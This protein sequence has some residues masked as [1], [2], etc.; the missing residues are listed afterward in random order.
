M[1][2]F[3]SNPFA[4]RI[5]VPAGTDVVFVSDA[6]VEDYVGGAELT[7]QA[8][9]DEADVK[10]FKLHSKDV[11]LDLLREGSRL[12]W[13]FGNFSAVE[14]ALLPVIISNLKYTVLEYDYKFCDHRSP[15][16]HQAATGK[17]C[18][19]H[20]RPHGQLISQFFYASMGTWWMSEAQQKR[21][22]E[23]FPL[24]AERANVVLSSV[25]DRRT[26]ASI[27]ALRASAAG[28]PRL[29]WIVLGS[30]SWIKGAAE[31]QRWCEEAG[32]EAEVVWDMPHSQLLQRLSTAIGHAY[33]P[34][35]GDTCPRLVIEAKLLGCQLHL[36]GNVQHA[37][38][39]WFSTD[40]LD[41]IEQHLAAAPALFW[42]GIRKMIDYRPTVSGYLTTYNCLSQGYPFE[43]CIRSMLQFCD[44]VCVVDGGS[45]DGTWEQLRSLSVEPKVKLKQVKRDWSLRHH[46]V[47]DGMQK[48]EARRMCTNEFCWQMDADEVVHQDDAAKVKELCRV[49][50]ASADIVACPVIEYWGGPD[51]VRL[52]V[53]PWK[54]R[55]SRNRPH[56]T[57]GIPM[58]LRRT[59]SD[60]SPCA[61]PGTDGCD[62][63][64]A[65]TGE[66]LPFVGFVT[67][68]VEQARRAALS[69]DERARQAYEGWFN[70]VVASIP[71]VF[72]YSWYDLPRKVRL[73]RDYWQ[74][75]WAALWDK[76]TTDTA[77]NNMMFPG[78][79][80]P[81][82]TSLLARRR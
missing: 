60:G 38:E 37:E 15:E 25:F 57:H 81:T 41:R 75:H 40:D 66:A 69:G 29:G 68:D 6:F 20:L 78:R 82:M 54:W 56:I 73:Y 5:E 61:W 34:K 44:E 76:D 77:A 70:Q 21:Y 79:T 22:F 1:I 19:C 26:L 2:D 31:A 58:Q 49:I 80:S 27:R 43:Q 71:G 32:K 24:L 62:M 33:L 42:S 72:H 11:S 48:A 50:P 35:G 59:A 30:P 67:P 74:N 45:T 10:V 8:L 12:L 4:R 13:I 53:P 3:T 23:R 51:K 14:S 39:E 46:P 63:V 18:D 52:D 28:Q 9:I 55:L 16:K 64:H 7:T 17:P 65:V 47:F 36:N